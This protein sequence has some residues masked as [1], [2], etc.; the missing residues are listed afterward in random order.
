MEKGTGVQARRKSRDKSSTRSSTTSS[1]IYPTVVL[2]DRK[3]S[4]SDAPPSASRR[5]SGVASPPPPLPPS[6]SASSR[7]MLAEKKSREQQATQAKDSSYDS[8]LTPSSAISSGPSS[9]VITTPPAEQLLTPPNATA[10]SSGLLTAHTEE[11]RPSLQHRRG[12]GSFASSIAL[13]DPLSDRW[14]SMSSQGYEKDNAALTSLDEAFATA[15]AKYGHANLPTLVSPTSPAMAS[16]PRLPAS[17]SDHVKSPSSSTFDIA[18]SSGKRS[19]STSNEH[20]Y[21]S[22]GAA[23][24]KELLLTQLLASLAHVDAQAYEPLRSI[25]EVEQCKAEV[26]RLEKKIVDLTHKLKVEMRVRDAADKVRRA[27]SSSSGSKA[28]KSTFHARSASSASSTSVATNAPVSATNAPATFEEL[29]KAEMDVVQARRKVDEVSKVLLEHKDQ[30][31]VARRR[32]LQHE[33]KVLALRVTSLEGQVVDMGRM[34]SEQSNRDEETEEEEAASSSGTGGGDGVRSTKKVGHNLAVEEV[35]ALRLKVER[36]EESLAHERREREKEV[37]SWR[38]K[39]DENL[40][41]QRLESSDKL[42]KE[43]Q[44]GERKRQRV[45]DEANREKRELEKQKAEADAQIKEAKVKVEE[46]GVS[47]ATER[48]VMRDHRQLL[49]AF[50][51]KLEKTESKLRHEDERCAKMLGKTEGREEM[52]DLLAQIKAGYGNAPK[53]GEKKTAGKDIDSLLDSLATHISD[54]ADE[55]AKAG[56]VFKQ[57]RRKMRQE[58]GHFYD[59][60]EDSMVGAEESEEDNDQSSRVREMELELRSTERELEKWRSEAESAKRQ[61]TVVQR[62]S[63][64]SATGSSIMGGGV[65]SQAGRS[66]DGHLGSRD[67]RASRGIASNATATAELEARITLLEKRNASL[68]EE[69]TQAKL[70]P[71]PSSSSSSPVKVPGAQPSKGDDASAR[72]Q[73][74]TAKMT[75]SSLIEALPEIPRALVAATTT[76][77][78]FDL[79]SLQ[80]AL[81]QRTA[82]TNVAKLASRFGA[83][84]K[85]SVESAIDAKYG[86]EVVERARGVLTAARLAVKRAMALQQMRASL[87]READE[88]QERCEDLNRAMEDLRNGQADQTQL[89]E[90]AKAREKKL[91]VLTLSFYLLM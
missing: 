30:A 39:H 27:L 20:R 83:Q 23:P 51:R 71:S 86:G 17:I 52:D 36:A 33:A 45:V 14:G 42:K 82:T 66:F 78:S 40:E 91:C 79:D 87:E 54:M 63:A 41:K 60:D 90:A 25:E 84:T 7:L 43:R 22:A 18:G 64:I 81:D 59:E 8:M 3:K 29:Q 57:R 32:L 68:E 53:K 28:A 11:R 70:M 10:S 65:G 50:E 73:L 56:G 16:S 75:L 2:E 31:N 58:E 80:K 9:S 37:E 88:A 6:T 76:D 49:E 77:D 12:K 72:Q 62:N 21:D 13:L 67:W 89:V 15:A 38:K 35:E 55:M 19:L 5:I 69:L 44:E 47:L 61:L 24:T 74:A 34:L 1:V 85:P 26:K 48:A 4:G 46:A